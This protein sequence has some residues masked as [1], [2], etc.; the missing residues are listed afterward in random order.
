[1]AE[2]TDKEIYGYGVEVVECEIDA[3]KSLLMSVQIPAFTEAVRMIAKCRGTIITSGCGGAG[4][5]AKRAAQGF[6]NV[7]RPSVFLSPGDAPHGDFGLIREGDVIVL[8]SKS[9]MSEELYLVQDV[10]HRRGASVI[11]ITENADTVLA[12]NSDIALVVDS[13]PEACPYQILATSSA[14]V[15]NAVTDMICICCMHLNDITEDYYKLIHPGGGVGK[16]F[17]EE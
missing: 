6:N 7:D 3:L 1:M 10:A 17:Q 4:Q 8:F 12:K 15:M 2:M 9:G 5:C 13:G 14:A 11:S 16:R